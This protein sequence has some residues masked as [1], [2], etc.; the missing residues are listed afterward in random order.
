MS[1]SHPSPARSKSGLSRTCP[2][3]NPYL[4]SHQPHPLQYFR[5][6]YRE[7]RDVRGEGVSPSQALA[8]SSAAISAAALRASSSLSGGKLTAPTRA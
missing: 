7:G 3:Y 5:T 2:D 1:A 4:V 6:Q 8:L